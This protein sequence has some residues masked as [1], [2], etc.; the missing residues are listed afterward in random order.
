[1]K[2]IIAYIPGEEL[3][4]RTVEEFARAV[5]TDVKVRKSDRH[6]PFQ[7]MYLTTGKPRKRCKSKKIT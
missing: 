4:A 6:P 3:A 5:F 1:M 2:I 7:H